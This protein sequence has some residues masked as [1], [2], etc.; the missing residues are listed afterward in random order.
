MPLLAAVIGRELSQWGILPL[1]LASAVLALRGLRVRRRVPA[2]PGPRPGLVIAA[3]VI[4]LV[5][6]TSASGLS[7]VGYLL[8]VAV[9]VL[10]ATALIA[11]VR[12]RP[13]VLWLLL[14]A[15][16]LLAAGAAVTGGLDV[17]GRLASQLGS[18]MLPTLDG[19]LLLGLGSLT[20]QTGWA[21]TGA[22]LAAA[23]A[24]RRASEGEPLTAVD[25]WLLRRR[26]LLTYLAA[27]ALVPYPLIRLTWLTPF[28]LVA[29]GPLEAPDRLWGLLL[30]AAAVLGIVLTLGLIRPWG[31]RFPRW[32]PVVGGRAVPLALALVPGGF[33]ALV[34][35][36]SAVPMF[37][38]VAAHAGTG[39]A[40]LVSLLIPTWFWGPMLGLAVWTYALHR[41]QD[42]RAA[43]P[44]R[45][46]P[47]PAPG[48]TYPSS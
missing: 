36:A 7:M 27:L 8:A 22:G 43:G 3:L 35:T 47:Q 4:G 11:L 12:S 13:R 29:P 34:A 2:A 46:A 26:R 33:V 18:T 20:L 9:P 31:E 17:V 39:Q 38:Q 24:G 25:G 21:V 37:V 30:G 45:P 6:L 28:P 10:T 19:P 15:L 48:K 1:A 32:F 16:L 40:V 42:S 41:V 5:W 14:P 44:A 23:G